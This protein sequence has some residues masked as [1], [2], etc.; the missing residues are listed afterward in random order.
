M[1]E[2]R[3]G[4][5]AKLPRGNIMGGWFLEPPTRPVYR[6]RVEGLP[7]LAKFYV[8]YPDDHRRHWRHY[9]TVKLD[10]TGPLR[11]QQVVAADREE[12]HGMFYD[13]RKELFDEGYMP[14]QFFGLLFVGS[15]IVD[16][17]TWRNQQM[18]LFDAHE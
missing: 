8:S 2:A 7:M 4:G 16:A 15:D 14:A 9:R 12:F 6:C 5:A 17:L 3:Q 13:L 18:G 11:P 10:G 1:T